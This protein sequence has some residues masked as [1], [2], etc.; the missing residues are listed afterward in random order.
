RADG[1]SPGGPMTLDLDAPP[2]RD[3]RQAASPIRPRRLRRTASLR[4][5]VR[6]TRV[7][8]SMLVAPLFVRPGSGIREP[9]PSMPGQARLSPDRAADEAERL[10][11]LGVGGV[12]LF[13][14]PERKD[15][16]GTEA[17]DDDGVIQTAFG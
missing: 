14:L 5:L 4:A 17:S 3:A 1:A 13:G 16:N 9:I 10:A 6:E 11:K 15:A 8:P 12:I 7:H 2:S